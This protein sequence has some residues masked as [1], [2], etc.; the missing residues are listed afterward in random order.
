[1]E[2]CCRDLTPIVILPSYIYETFSLWLLH[3][4]NVTKQATF[5]E[6][7]KERKSFIF[8]MVFLLRPFSV[9]WSDQCLIIST[10]ESLKRQRISQQ[11]TQLQGAREMK[12]TAL[13]NLSQQMSLRNF[14]LNFHSVKQR[15]S[16]IYLVN[17]LKHQA[18]LRETK[19]S[20]P[21]KPE[22]KR[23]Y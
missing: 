13:R 17:A 15:D 3:T 7:Y 4:V 23:D 18:R 6:E 14:K 8:N 22:A 21:A 10:L 2:K 16:F 5:Y 9:V 11:Q 1:M 19:I 20:H 12:H